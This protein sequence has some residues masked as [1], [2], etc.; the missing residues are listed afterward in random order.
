M[1][2]TDERVEQLRQ[3]WI[4]GKSASQIATLLGHGLSRNAVIGKVHRLGMACRAKSP[5]SAAPRPRVSTPQ[6]QAHRP[7]APRATL[8]AHRVV[9]GATALALAPLTDA[10]TEP[11]AYE[12]VVLPMSLRVTIVELK[13]AMCRWPLGDPATPD[14]RYCGSPAASGPYCVHHGRLAYQPPQERRRERE[15]QRRLPLR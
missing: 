7:G 6:Q 5:N 10:E 11:E 1:S 13:E 2:W 14:F 4:D 8:V 12:S 9:R 15:R 3:Y